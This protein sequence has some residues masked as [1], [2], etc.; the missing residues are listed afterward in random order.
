M[1][2]TDS[3]ITFPTS[4]TMVTV[5]IILVVVTVSLSIISWRRSRYRPANGILELLRVI[6]V[7]LV[8]LTLN[9]PEWRERFEPEEKPVVAIL[10]DRSGSM[11]TEDIVGASADPKSASS[12]AALAEQLGDDATW[13]ELEADFAITRR[14][15]SS[16]S[17][18]ATDLGGALDAVLEEEA[19][20]RAVVLISDGD[21][22][23]GEPPS[24]IATRFRMEETPVFAL[25]TGSEQRLPDIEVSAFDVPTFGIAGKPVRL[26]FTVKSAF[27]TNQNVT[28]EVTTSEGETFSHDV[29]IPALGRVA[30]AL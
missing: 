13:Q 18:V 28:L 7:A 6:I 5:G 22:N 21:W 24:R 17:G 25:A 3:E 9:Q 16:E 15:F 4:P 12:R 8:A 20:L 19:A 11:A 2:L 27:P 29:L 10:T 26:P 1:T 23:E 14:D 30:D